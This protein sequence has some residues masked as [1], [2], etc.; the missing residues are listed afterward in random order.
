MAVSAFAFGEKL[1]PVTDAVQVADEAAPP[2]TPA[3]VTVEPTHIVWS[4]PAFTVASGLMVR[5]IWSETAVQGPAGSFV[6][7]VNVIAPVYP[8]GGV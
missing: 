8:A 7:N 4:G 2:I 1:P 6:V 5:T 3:S